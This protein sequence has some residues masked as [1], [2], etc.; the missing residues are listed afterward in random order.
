MLMGNDAVPWSAA[1]TRRTRDLQG[2][3]H[4]EAAERLEISEKAVEEAGEAGP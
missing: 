1:T 4:S 2:P 3:A